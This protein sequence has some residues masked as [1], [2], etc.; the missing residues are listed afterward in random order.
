MDAKSVR[1][2]GKETWILVAALA[3][4]ALLLGVCVFARHLYERRRAS[5]AIAFLNQP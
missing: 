3:A 5:T 4:L 1:L 2:D